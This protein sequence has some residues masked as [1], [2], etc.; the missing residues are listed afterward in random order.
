MRISDWSSDVCSSDLFLFRQRPE[1]VAQ[2]SEP[3]GIGPPRLHAVAVERAAH[4]LA[5]RG[6]DDAVELVEFEHRRVPVEPE[7][8]QRAAQMRFGTAD[9]RVIGAMMDQTRRDQI[10]QA[11]CRERWVQSWNITRVATILQTK[12]P[13]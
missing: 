12:R 13:P 4:L 5:R 1:L 9:H 8:R 2:R 10:R 11:S 3:F 6:A 7:M